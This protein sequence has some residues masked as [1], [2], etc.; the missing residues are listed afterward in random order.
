MQRSLLRFPLHA[1]LKGLPFESTVSHCALQA[2]VSVDGHAALT[3][4]LSLVFVGM[5]M[6]AASL[7]HSLCTRRLPSL[8]LALLIALLLLA[9]FRSA[10]GSLRADLLIGYSEGSHESGEDECEDKMSPEMCEAYKS[11]GMCITGGQCLRKLP[12]DALPMTGRCTL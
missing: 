5:Y 4:H 1:F 11:S 6:P 9:P 7:P 10:R 8:L 2:A 3:V 12:A